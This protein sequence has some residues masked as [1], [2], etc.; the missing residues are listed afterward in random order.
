MED[1]AELMFRGQVAEIQKAKG[2][3]DIHKSNYQRRTQSA[4]GPDDVAFIQSRQ[5]FYIAS[6]NSDGWPYVQHRGGPAGFL[7]VIGPNR[8]ACLDYVGNRQ[9]ITMGHV[10]EDPRVSLFLMDYM[11]QTRMKLQ[12]RASLTPLDEADPSIINHFSA[13][14]T[15]AERLLVVEVVAMD[16]NCTKYIPPFVP[17]EIAN[18]AT[19]RYTAELQAEN[20]ALRAKLTELKT[21]GDQA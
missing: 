5:S 16:W 9:F 10:A 15:P 14:G 18:E 6:V 12:G 20:A 3:H 2:Y 8:V 4:L 1:Y 11:R 7:K 19:E 13:A 17:V 21:D